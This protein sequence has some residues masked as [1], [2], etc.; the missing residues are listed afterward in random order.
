MKEGLKV[1]KV[2]VISSTSII[3]FR[4]GDESSTQAAEPAEKGETGHNQHIDYAEIARGELG[5]DLSDSDIS[6]E[7]K[8]ELLT[9]LGQNIDVF[10]TSIKE[11]G[12]ASTIYQHTINTF[13]ILPQS[14][15]HHIVNTHNMR[16]Y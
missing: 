16:A 9:F 1:A 3:H 12:S 13:T 6:D 4:D 8:Q 10:A 11:L 15:D 2:C 7:D 5:V 14:Q